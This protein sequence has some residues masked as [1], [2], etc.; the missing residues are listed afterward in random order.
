MV[1]L[2]PIYFPSKLCGCFTN[3]IGIQSMPA[4]HIH[5]SE[6][7]LFLLRV[8]ELLYHNAI[9]FLTSTFVGPR[10]TN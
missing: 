6:M 10:G 9:K 2:F 4:N 3:L 1:L 5:T 8:C 7:E